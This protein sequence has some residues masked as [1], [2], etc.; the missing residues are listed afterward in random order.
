MVSLTPITKRAGTFDQNGSNGNNR[1]KQNGFT[2]GHTQD[3]QQGTPATTGATSLARQAPINYAVQYPQAA[4][5]S[6]PGQAI[7]N[8]GNGISPNVANEVMAGGQPAWAPSNNHNIDNQQAGIVYQ[9]MGIAQV[10][11]GQGFVPNG[12]GGQPGVSSPVGQAGYSVQYAPIGHSYSQHQM[13]SVADSNGL[14]PF[15]HSSQIP[16]NSSNV[17]LAFAQPL[18]A[19]PLAGVTQLAPGQF[20]YA[21]GPVVGGSGSNVQPQGGQQTADTPISGNNQTAN[22]P[23]TDKTR[24]QATQTPSHTNKSPATNPYNQTEP[25]NFAPR[26]D[27]LP[28]QPPPPFMIGTAYTHNTNGTQAGVVASSVI[29]PFSAVGN[30]DH[31]IARIP[32]HHSGYETPNENYAV[33]PHMPISG[34][35]PPEVR[36]ARSAQ[37]NRLTNGP[38][39]LPPAEVAL[40]PDNF[41]FI[42]SCSQ[43]TASDAGVVKI[44]NVSLYMLSMARPILTQWFYHRFL[45]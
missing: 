12:P 21:Y 26:A 42:E 28:A 13:A 38:Y 27:S 16:T 18:H 32:N 15:L 41:P 1:G 25:R 11:S 7:P 31:A 6:Q 8:L 44:K 35:P 17:P 5:H 37:L 30:D 20:Y 39:G 34:P 40:H 23:Q 10:Q 24:S 29:D 45:T 36:A 9:H 22:D 14:T 33:I 19:Q 2:T 3:R 43:A 4:Q